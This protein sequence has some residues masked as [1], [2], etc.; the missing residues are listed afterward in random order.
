MV[1]GPVRLALPTARAT[2]RAGVRRAAR[3]SSL[4][5]VGADLRCARAGA[6]PRRRRAAVRAGAAAR[7]KP[8]QA[9]RR[10]QRTGLRQGPQH[11][12]R[13]RRRR[14]S[15]T[16]VAS[17]RPTRSSTTARPSASTPRA[18]PSSPT[19]AATSPTA[20]RFDLTDD[21]GDGFAESVQTIA[22]DK[23]RFTSPRVERSEGDVTVFKRRLYRLRALQGPSGKAAALAGARRPDHREPANP[24]RLLRGRLARSRRRADRLSSRIS[25]RP[26]RR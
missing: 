24:R 10:G 23:T 4:L 19:S 2:A 16:R 9:D 5:L 1:D 12:H 21:F 25:R 26:T 22:T 7:A 17:C 13:G 11:R 6:A 14:S 18:T 3:R 15:T 20:Q 8:R